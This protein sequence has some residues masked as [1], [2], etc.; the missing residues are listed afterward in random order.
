VRLLLKHGALFWQ[1]DEKGERPYDYAKR[2]KPSDRDEILYLL[3]DGPRIEDQGFRDAVEAIQTGDL[4]GLRRMLDARPSLL[5]ERAIE[6]ELGPRGYFSDPKLFWFIANNPTLIPSLP[7]NIVAIAEEMLARGVAQEDRDYALGLVTTN[8]LMPRGQQID[9]VRTLVNAGAQPG[10]MLGSLGHRQVAPAVWL[11]D[12]GFLALT[13]PIAAGLGRV[14]A[15]PALLDAASQQERTQALG[16]ATIN[17][18]REAAALCLRSGADP[19]AFMPCHQHST[20]LHQAAIDNDVEMLELLIAHGARADIEDTMWRGTALGWAL[21][22]AKA[23][24]A[25]YLRGLA[26]PTG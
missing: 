20:P 24:A 19:N 9:L 12:N 26:K 2:G 22:G 23:E 4:A 18:Q 13:A 11:L 14:A 17:G 15:L 16:M 8:G 1:G 21:H 3:A 25:A 7:E 5:S 6:P 10:D